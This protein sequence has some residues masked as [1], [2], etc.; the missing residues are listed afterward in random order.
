VSKH[1]GEMMHVGV[2]KRAGFGLCNIWLKKERKQGRV[3]GR[4]EG[5]QVHVI[6]KDCDDRDA[7]FSP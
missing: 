7:F 5:A 6:G 3:N 1:I 4:V 2:W